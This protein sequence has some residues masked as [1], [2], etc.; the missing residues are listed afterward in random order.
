MLLL[1]VTFASFVV[2]KCIHTLLCDT[3]AFLYSLLSVVVV[4]F[5]SSDFI[6]CSVMS[7]AG[8]ILLFTGSV[9]ALK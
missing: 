5:S 9:V 4:F 8:C 6:C 7:V 3:T 1:A 2:K